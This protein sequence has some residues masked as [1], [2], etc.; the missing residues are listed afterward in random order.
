MEDTASGGSMPE[1]SKNS[2][3]YWF[4]RIK[5]LGIPTP[6]TKVVSLNEG[7]I[8]EYYE[9]DGDCFDT[10]RVEEEISSIIT[11]D[12]SLPVFLRTDEYSGKHSWDKSCYLSSLNERDLRRHLFEIISGSKMAGGF[13]DLE[14][15]ALVIRE[16]IPMDTRFFAFRGNMP[17]NPERRYFVRDGQVVC[18]HPYWIEEA[19]ERGTQKGSL[20]TNWKELAKEMNFESDDEVAL[21]TDYSKRVANAL[22]GYWSVDFCKAK[23]NRWILIDMAL[24]ENSWH[25]S[26]CKYS[27]MPKITRPEIDPIS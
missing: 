27:N 18:H 13:G 15:S 24:G 11:S 5:D 10:R 8:R 21:L 1:K 17:V 16:F 3:S 4:P 25:L 9:G 2:L 23:D 7:E 14:I 20:P 19:V 22:E 6:K 12:F 26:E